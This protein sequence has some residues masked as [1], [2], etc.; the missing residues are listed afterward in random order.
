M[1]S[2]LTLKPTLAA[3]AVSLPGRFDLYGPV[4]KGL[5]AFLGHTLVGL[6]QMDP[7]SDLSVKSALDQLDELLEHCESHLQKEDH[8]VHP[9]ID[10]QRAGFSARIAAEHA[11]HAHAMLALRAGAD[12]LAC[13]VGHE[14]VAAAAALYRRFAGFVADNL[15]HM[16]IEESQH[17]ALLWS[18]LDDAALA[19]IHA[20]IVAATSATDLALSARWMVPHLA[21]AERCMLLAGAQATMPATV[22]DGLM[23]LLRPHLSPVQLQQLGAELGLKFG[24]EPRL[25]ASAR[26]IVEGFLDAAF[27][28]FDVAAATSLVSADFIAHPWV[29]LGAPAGPAGLAAI[30][31]LFGQAFS[32]VRAEVIDVVSEGERIAARYRYAGRHD[33]PL[34]GIAPTGRDFEIGGLAILRIDGQGRIA[35][36]WREED[37]MTLQRQLGVSSLLPEHHAQG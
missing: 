16:E 12:A 3:P 24:Q 18:C 15:V 1:T 27:V 25:A 7:L 22:F 34:F 26:D 19:A 36:F 2:T 29:V 14:R 21:P 9:V 5:R 17:N 35:E 31:P 37:M 6:G 32:A 20:R 11:E 33:G 30:L 28:R 23:Q 13:A 4:H 8:Y 10:G